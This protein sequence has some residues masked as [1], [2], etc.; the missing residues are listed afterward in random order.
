MVRYPFFQF[1][2]AVSLLL[3]GGNIRACQVRSILTGVSE[4]SDA[5]N[6]SLCDSTGLP[7]SADADDDRDTKSGHDQ[8]TCPCEFRKGLAQ[9]ERLTMDLSIPLCPT[10]PL[11]DF[12]DTDRFSV[13]VTPPANPISADCKLQSPPLLI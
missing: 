1:L 7:T 5:V 9:P 10:V 4:K 8:K 6:I 2:L 12:I 3:Q 11:P 13:F